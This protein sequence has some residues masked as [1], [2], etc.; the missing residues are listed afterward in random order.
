MLKKV[1]KVLAVL[2]SLPML[3]CAAE[4]TIGAVA[5]MPLRLGVHAGVNRIVEVSDAP[6]GVYADGVG[7]GAS[8]SF[9]ARYKFLPWLYLHSEIGIDYRYFASD[10]MQMGFDC[11]CESGGNWSG[12]NKDYLL[13]LEIPLL[14]QAHIPNVLYFEAGP[15]FDFKLM[16]K[17]SFFLPKSVRTDKCHEDRFFG[18]GLSFGIGHEFSFGLFID[19][20][21]SHQLTDVVTV[22][23]TC[24]SYTVSWGSSRTDNANGKESVQQESGYIDESIVGSHYLINKI[25]LGIG[26]W[27]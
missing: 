17:S 15:V 18:A 21:F 7:Y 19:A 22:D 14:A 9:D 27:F 26:Y 12:K 11:D 23:K 10:Y 8:L 1:A 16:R 20:R 3:V 13:S 4:P 25:Q 2:A 24:G 5:K 6:W